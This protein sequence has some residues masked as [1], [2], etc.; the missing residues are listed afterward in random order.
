MDQIEFVASVGGGAKPVSGP[1]REEAVKS[2][3]VGKWV[4]VDSAGMDGREKAAR[5]GWIF[6]F[7]K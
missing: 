5:T 4:R 6:I 7:L 2:S 1:G 3:V